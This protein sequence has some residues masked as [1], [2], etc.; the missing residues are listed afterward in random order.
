MRGSFRFHDLLYRFGGEEFVVLMR[1]AKPCGEAF[2]RLRLN[3][4][5]YAFPQVGRITVS[6]GF[7]ECAPA[8]RRQRPSSGPTRRSI[9]PRPRPQPGAQLR[10]PGGQRH[11]PEATQLSDVELF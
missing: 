2:E 1:C 6:I 5:R 3:T 7:T 9:T 8:T 11:D 4:E 10:G